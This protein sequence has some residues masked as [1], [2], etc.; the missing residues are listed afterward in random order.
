MNGVVVDARKDGA[1]RL[2]LGALPVALQDAIRAEG[3]DGGAGKLRARFEMPISDDEVY[4]SRTHPL[5]SG[6]AS[7]VMDAALDPL[8]QDGDSGRPVARRCGAIRTGQVAARTTVLLARCRYQVVTKRVGAVPL[9]QLAEECLVLGFESAPESARWLDGEGLEELLKAAPDANI[10]PEQATDYVSKVVDGHGALEGHLAAVASARCEALADAHR[11]VR[12]A[13]RQRGVSYEV[14]PQGAPDVL[15]IYVYLPV[16][17][18][19]AA[20]GGTP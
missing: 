19:V 4:L 15:G 18:A 12:E 13:A 8:L 14:R 7:Y 20:A 1:V 11:R 6:L 10:A 9:E 3:A 16:P 2:D 5:V 17:A